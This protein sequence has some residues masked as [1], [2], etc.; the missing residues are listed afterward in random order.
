ML[1]ERH[2]PEEVWKEVC[3]VFEEHELDKY[4]VERSRRESY[5]GSGEPLQWEVEEVE[6]KNTDESIGRTLLAKD[7]LAV[8]GVTSHRE[9]VH[10]KLSDGR[11]EA[12]EDAERY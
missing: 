6:R 1:Q 11:C 4:E 2:C 5:R 8:E 7:T 9:D 10:A 12:G 3:F